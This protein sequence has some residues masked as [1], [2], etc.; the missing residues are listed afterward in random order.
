MRKLKLVVLFFTIFSFLIVNDILT[1]VGGSPTG[2]SGGAG[3]ST[4]T[5]CHSG[6]VNSGPGT[7]SITSDAPAGVYTPGM[8][9]TITVDIEQSG[10][11]RY[12]FIV[13]SGYSSTEN[14]SLGTLALTNTSETQQKAAGARRYVTHRQAGTAG[15]SGSKSWSFEWTAP[16]SDKGDIDFF[17][18]G[19]AA[20]NNGSTSGDRIYTSS[21]TLSPVPVSVDERES[22]SVVVFPTRVENTLKVKVE[23]FNSRDLQIRILNASGQE[24]ESVR[25]SMIGSTFTREIDTQAWARGIYFVEVQGDD[26]RTVEKVI[27]F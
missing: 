26:F 18:S 16:G 19:N 10:I 22:A 11:Q 4:C 12:G 23:N 17:V 21:L 8:T 3:E 9:Y 1:N 6:A 25:Q 13:L 15:A 20:N 27:R 7:I 14:A 5:A 24:V 2:R